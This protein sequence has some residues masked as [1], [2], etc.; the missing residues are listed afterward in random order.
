MQ[1]EEVD[2]ENDLMPIRDADTSGNSRHKKISISS[3]KKA[4]GVVTTRR[5]IYVSD[6]VVLDADVEDPTTGGTDVT[7]ELQAL[8]TAALTEPTHFIF[9]GAA[10][11]SDH[12]LV[13]GDIEMTFLGETSG[14]VKV[15]DSYGHIIMSANAVRGPLGIANNKSLIIN[16]GIFHGNFANSNPANR[17]V[18]PGSPF[19]KVGLALSSIEN[20]EL[21]GITIREAFTFATLLWTI[22]KAKINDCVIEWPS[23][24]ATTQWPFPNPFTVFNH[25]GLHMWG[26]NGDFEVNNLT[27]LYNDDD[28]LAINLGENYAAIQPYGLGSPTASDGYLRSFIL[29]GMYINGT[30]QVRLLSYAT[31]AMPEDE[32]GTLILRNVTGNASRQDSKYG[33]IQDITN[34]NNGTQVAYKGPIIGRI[35]IEDWNVTGRGNFQA[36]RVTGDITANRIGANSTLK[37]EASK[38][39]GDYYT[40]PLIIAPLAVMRKNNL[41]GDYPA[42]VRVLDL[43]TGNTKTLL[44]SSLSGVDGGWAS[45]G[46]SS[47]VFAPTHFW[48]FKIVGGVIPDLGTGTA[49]DMAYSGGTSVVAGSFGSA[50]RVPKTD[51]ARA[52]LD[53]TSY[54]EM[55]IAT[56]FSWY[57]GAA[58]GGQGQCI[59]EYDVGTGLRT[60][61]YADPVFSSWVLPDIRVLYYAS[62][63]AFGWPEINAASK[64]VKANSGLITGQQRRTQFICMRTKADG[65]I[66]L[67][68]GKDR[69]DEASAGASA[70]NAPIGGNTPTISMGYPPRNAN[71]GN[72]LFEG[73]GVW[74]TALPDDIILGMADLVRP[75]M[76][77]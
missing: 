30:D 34:F 64:P 66:T 10:L 20:L 76:Q 16:G 24:S 5:E 69:I 63:T 26:K 75:I 65:T 58:V 56:W 50:L 61:V 36:R 38:Y 43:D 71:A 18:A 49:A 77:P 70:W 15:A 23:E 67:F 41:R 28:A 14:L 29:D 39:Y 45:D 19:W 17:V 46:T 72:F 22:D 53:L 60:S 31:G 21:N 8:F 32:I 73:M 11:L 40:R 3:L 6:Y 2:V 4:M 33:S 54:T 13:G 57:P 37:V 52:T 47:T 12:L 7:S 62:G 51:Y 74:D 1:F 35:V 59:W 48:D 68:S 25:D 42:G 9:D 27:I 55:T 44:A